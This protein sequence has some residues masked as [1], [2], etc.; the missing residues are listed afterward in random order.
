MRTHEL[1][2]ESNGRIFTVEFIKKDGSLR[3]MTARLG[4]KKGLTGKGMRYDP[5][6]RGLLPV[7]DMQKKDY[8]MVNLRTIQSLKVNGANYTFEVHPADIPVP[9]PV[10]RLPIRRRR[11]GYLPVSPRRRSQRDPN[12]CSHKHRV[13]T[14]TLPEGDG[15]RV[16]VFSDK[17]SKVG[18]TA[19]GAESTRKVYDLLCLIFKE[20][21]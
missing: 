14:Y 16:D 18:C 3:K 1:I 15:W 21:K 9:E 13:G 20:D 19:F 5:I 6:E 7:W 11:F 4:V 8:R 2:R 12:D 10:R 17:T